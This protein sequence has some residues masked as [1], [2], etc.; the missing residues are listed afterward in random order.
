M[1]VF[2]PSFSPVTSSSPVSVTRHD[3]TLEVSV[4]DNPLSVESSDPITRDER[5]H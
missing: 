2:V 3:D 4:M 1:T 5:V